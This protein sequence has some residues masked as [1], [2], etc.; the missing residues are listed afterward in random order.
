MT[1][2]GN[3]LILCYWVES[4]YKNIPSNKENPS[5]WVGTGFEECLLRKSSGNSYDPQ[6]WALF[7]FF[8]T[9]S[10]FFYLLCSQS[11]FMRRD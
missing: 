11:F 3:P 6:M 7:Q 8:F 5:P 2:Y 10:D 9:F 4:L 1:I